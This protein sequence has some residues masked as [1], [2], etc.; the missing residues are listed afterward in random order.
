MCVC[1]G[2]RGGADTR[3]EKSQSLS[4]LLDKIKAPFNGCSEKEITATLLVRIHS[5]SRRKMH[6]L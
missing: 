1:W 6:D 5:E 3:H 4:K 2:G